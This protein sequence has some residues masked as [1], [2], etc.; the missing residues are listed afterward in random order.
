MTI[1][2]PPSHT[3][4]KGRNVTIYR[5]WQL[6][7][8]D[9]WFANK[10]FKVFNVVSYQVNVISNY[11]EISSQ[12]SQNDAHKGKTKISQ[13]WWGCGKRWTL[14][15]CWSEYS[16]VLWQWNHALSLLGKAKSRASIWQSYTISKNSVSYYK[17]PCLE[18][19]LL[20]VL[21]E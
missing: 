12:S 6:S 19:C 8:E 11:F 16:L 15:H 21:S 1:N 4:K 3:H 7:G 9:I 2:T 18:S 5:N 17:D 14:T 20:L 10:Y 13:W